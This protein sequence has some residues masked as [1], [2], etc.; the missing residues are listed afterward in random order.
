MTCVLVA[1]SPKIDKDRHAHHDDRGLA[2]DSRRS[3][4]FVAALE[5]AAGSGT[6]YDVLKHADQRNDD[7]TYNATIEAFYL[8]PAGT[9][10]SGRPGTV[11]AAGAMA[12]SAALLGRARGRPAAI[13]RWIFDERRAVVPAARH[14]RIHGE[15]RGTCILGVLPLRHSVTSAEEESINSRADLARAQRDVFDA[16]N[17]QTSTVR[18]DE[19]LKRF[20]E[21]VLATSFLPG[22]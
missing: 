18:A 3:P 20:Y 22:P 14:R 8:P 6:F 16:K 2:A 21:G 7:G 1:V 15:C 5:G 12:G 13:W 4:A 10:P 11:R 9:R 19:E 17:A